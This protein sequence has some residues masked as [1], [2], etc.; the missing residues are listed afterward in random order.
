[1]RTKWSCLVDAKGGISE[2]E[3]KTGVDYLSSFTQVIG[4]AQALLYSS[5]ENLTFFYYKE[6]PALWFRISLCRYK[7]QL[8]LLQAEQ[9]ALPFELSKRELEILTLL[10]SGLSNMEI[11]TRLYISERTVAKHVEHLFQK[12]A[13]DNRTILAVFSVTENL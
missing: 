12:T 4:Y 1:M 2:W 10:S 13:I 3:D 6:E 5:R 8:T 7:Q 11:A 9:T